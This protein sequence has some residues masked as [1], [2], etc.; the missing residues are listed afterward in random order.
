MKLDKFQRGLLEAATENATARYNDRTGV[1]SAQVI[2]VLREALID[3]QRDAFI[4]GAKWLL[5]YQI[6]RDSKGVQ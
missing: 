4:D 3:A 2:N 5:A 1:Y 6:E